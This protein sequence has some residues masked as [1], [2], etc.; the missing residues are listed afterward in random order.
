MKIKQELFNGSPPGSNGV[1]QVTGWMTAESFLAYPKHLA[2]HVKPLPLENP[3]L[4][5]I[6]NHSSWDYVLPKKWNS[7]SQVFCSYH[8]ATSITRCLSFWSS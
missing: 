1:A 6:D 4:L 7:Y 3:V 5:L 2:R 8:T